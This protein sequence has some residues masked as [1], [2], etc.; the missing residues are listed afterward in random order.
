MTFVGCG[1][2]SDRLLFSLQ[3][4]EHAGALTKQYSGG[5][6]RKLSMAIALIGSPPVLFLDEPTTGSDAITML[7]TCIH[8]CIYTFIN[9]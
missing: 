1:V 7:R 9:I 2:A 4:S 5:T 8:T 6:K 3:L